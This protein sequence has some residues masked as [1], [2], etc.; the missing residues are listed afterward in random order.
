MAMLRRARAIE[1]CPFRK[2]QDSNIAI[3]PIL[4]SIQW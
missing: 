3:L 2:T 4:D 1:M